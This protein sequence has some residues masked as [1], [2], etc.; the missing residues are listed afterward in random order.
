[1]S[2]NAKSNPNENRF[3]RNQYKN[4]MENISMDLIR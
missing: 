4:A 2:Q 3:N 1:M